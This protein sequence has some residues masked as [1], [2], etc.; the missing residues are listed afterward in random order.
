MFCKLKT[1]VSLLRVIV[2]L[3]SLR[4]FGTIPQKTVRFSEQIMSVDKYPSTFSRFR[5]KQSN[6]KL[7][8]LQ[9][10]YKI[11]VITFVNEFKNQVYRLQ[12]L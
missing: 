3:L 8:H 12:S 2:T 4:P 5:A 7:R 9:G 6:E 10:K 11:S 1:V